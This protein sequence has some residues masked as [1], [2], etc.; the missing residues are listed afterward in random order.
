MIA[1]IRNTLLTTTLPPSKT[2]G[3]AGRQRGFSLLE[4]LIVLG[5]VG[6]MAAFAIPALQTAVRRT[7]LTGYV[8]ATELMMRKARIEAIRRGRRVGVQVNPNNRIVRSFVDEDGSCSPTAGDTLLAIA[9]DGTGSEWLEFKGPDMSDP[10]NDE[11]VGFQGTCPL[12]AGP[13]PPLDPNFPDPPEGGW[14]TFDPS[15]AALEIGGFRFGD[16]HRNFL[17]VRVDPQATG[18]ISIRKWDDVNSV[19]LDNH[20]GGE[21]WEWY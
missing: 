2:F 15:G 19:W 8:Q 11:L 12:P 21:A 3:L 13:P 5:V 7:K 16:Q 10:N 6:L 9:S 18:K 20:Q 14:V 17:E 4:V 1:R